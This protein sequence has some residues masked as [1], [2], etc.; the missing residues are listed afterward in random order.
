[1]EAALGRN[2]S[3][4]ETQYSNMSRKL[5]RFGSHSNFLDLLFHYDLRFN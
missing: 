3:Q 1:M 2:E 5:A 4:D